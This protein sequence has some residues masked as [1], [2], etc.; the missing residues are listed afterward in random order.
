MRVETDEDF[1]HVSN[2]ESCIE[3]GLEEVFDG[4][5]R[6]IF[7]RT[8]K[9]HILYYWQLFDD[10]HLLSHSLCKLSD[11][12]R[13]DSNNVPPTTLTTPGSANKDND[14]KLEMEFK[15]KVSNSFSQLACN[16]SLNQHRIEKKSFRELRCEYKDCSDDEEKRMLKKDMEESEIFLNTLKKALGF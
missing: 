8:E 1:G 4:D 5:N 11:S 10:N 9:S 13:V 6:K 15:E 2:N 16:N 12:V 14:K 7:L 3:Q